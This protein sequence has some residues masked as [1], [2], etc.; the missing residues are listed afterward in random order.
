MNW[1]QIRRN[2]THFKVRAKQTW[3]RLSERELDVIRGVRDQ[4]IEKVQETYGIAKAEAEQQVM[5]FARRLKESGRQASRKVRVKGREAMRKAEDLGR[6]AAGRALGAASARLD[7]ARNSIERGG[8]RGRT[9]RRSRPG[10]ASRRN[11][12]RR[13]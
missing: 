11:R 3:G 6:A 13:R 9:T 8:G 7:R 5:A 12:S 1:N 2:W 10:T 4:L